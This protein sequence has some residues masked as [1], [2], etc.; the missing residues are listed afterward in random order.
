MIIEKKYGPTLSISEE[1]HA[2]KYRSKGESFKGAMIRVADALKDNEEHYLQ[3]KEVLPDQ[4]FLSCWSCTS[5]Y[6]RT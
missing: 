5:S 3:F 6:G 4:R 2:M 1:I